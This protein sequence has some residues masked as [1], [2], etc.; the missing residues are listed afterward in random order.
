M[1]VSCIMPTFRRFHCVEKSIGYFLDQEYKDAELIIFNTDTDYPLQLGNSLLPFSD[2]VKIINNNTDFITGAA[3]TNVGALRRDSL[4]YASG[5]YY[6]CW[7]DDDIYLPWHLLQGIEG[8]KRTGRKAFKPKESFFRNGNRGIEI[9]RNVMEAS[10]I[11]DIK[12]VDY[13]LESGKEHLKWYLKLRDS[14]QLNENELDTIPAYCFDWSY[15]ELAAHK[16]SGDIDNPDNFSRHKSKSIDY[17]KRRLE[18]IDVK[19]HYLPFL[20]FLRNK[21]INIR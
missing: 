11:V 7:D 3:Y 5:E 8:I 16:Q 14:G 9:V 13:N 20:E 19:D 21:N 18:L 12:E 4:T 10:I 1:T 6:N 15:N 2:R 17:A